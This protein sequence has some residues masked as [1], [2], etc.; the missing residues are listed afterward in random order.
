MKILEALLAAIL[1]FALYMA[2]TKPKY[3]KKKIPSIKFGKVQV[4]PSLKIKFKTQTIHLHH[5]LWLTA[6][7]GL[8]NHIAQGLGNLIYVKLFVIGGI[9]QGFT[10]KDRFR[11]LVKKQN[12]KL[13]DYLKISVVIPAYNEEKYLADTLKSLQKQ[14]YKPAEII[15]VDNNSEDQTSQIAKDFDAKVVFE[16]RIGVGSARQAGFA[17]ASSQIIATTDADTIVPKNWLKDIALQFA[18][19][20]SLVAYAGMYLFKDGPILLRTIGSYLNILQFYLFNWYSGANFAVKNSVFQKSGGFDTSLNLS[21]D[22]NLG[23]KLKTYGKVKFAPFFTVTT[24]GRRFYRG[25]LVGLF[26]Y[27]STYLKIKLAKEKNKVEFSPVRNSGDLPRLNLTPA[28]LIA[29]AIFLVVIFFAPVSPTHAKATTVTKRVK[30]D[31][32]M[33]VNKGEKIVT[34]ELHKASRITRKIHPPHVYK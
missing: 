9:I 3:L 11:V 5:W 26:L 21:E 17:K 12:P 18:G 22:T 33:T 24:S 20:S 34:Y 32:T 1:G 6:T 23:R 8:V 16:P 19:D 14:T 7:L 15:V 13:T 29:F 31:V 27:A 10:F 25:I 28:T 4:L 2:L 30:H